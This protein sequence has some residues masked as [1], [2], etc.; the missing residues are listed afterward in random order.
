MAHTVGEVVLAPPAAAAPEPEVQVY[1]VDDI[2]FIM[3]HQ[4]DLNADN[5]STDLLDLLGAVLRLRADLA[6]ATEADR[7]KNA[8]K[9]AKHTAAWMAHGQAGEDF[10]VKWSSVGWTRDSRMPIAHDWHEYARI[11]PYEPG[12]MLGPPAHLY[13][14]QAELAAKAA[15]RN[16]R[17]RCEQAAAALRDL[18][19]MTHVKIG[20]MRLAM[21]RRQCE[22]RTR[23]NL[24]NQVLPGRC[25]RCGSLDHQ[26]LDFCSS[27]RNQR[28]CDGP[29]ITPEG[30]V[31]YWCLMPGHPSHHCQ[32]C[33]QCGRWGHCHRA[34]RFL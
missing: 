19:R 20:D 15:E 11:H 23:L 29:W 7:R 31:C 2:D 14:T 5:M 32:Q 27:A 30:Q 34:C 4:I 3:R 18:R 9:D 28:A 1:G 22:M 6:P 10:R 8:E 21:L 24:G 33:T 26:R 16:F 17:R 13:L 25:F 12:G